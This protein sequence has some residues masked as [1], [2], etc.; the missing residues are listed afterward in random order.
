ML[1]WLVPRSA[2]GDSFIGKAKHNLTTRA[3]SSFS[4][5]DVLLG[6]GE[7]TITVVITLICLLLSAETTRPS[8]RNCVIIKGTESRDFLLLFQRLYQDPI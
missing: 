6:E 5:I 4:Y 1:E 8:F 7:G 3:I 2:K